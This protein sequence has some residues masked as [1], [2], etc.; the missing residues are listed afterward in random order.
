MMHDYMCTVTNTDLGLSYASTSIPSMTFGLVLM[1][2]SLIMLSSWYSLKDMYLKLA[3][4]ISQTVGPFNFNSS[5]F[6][7]MPPLNQKLSFLRELSQTVAL[8][9]CSGV[10]YVSLASY[11]MR[12]AL[13]VWTFA[14][15]FNMLTRTH[16][17]TQLGNYVRTLKGVLCTG[18][19]ERNVKYCKFLL[20]FAVPFRGREGVVKI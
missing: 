19:V 7:I 2:L 5:I 12:C 16:I 8:H 15:R 20:T 1:S 13:L 18:F 6:L 4:D 3:S 17:V 14:R 10:T 9:R 11:I